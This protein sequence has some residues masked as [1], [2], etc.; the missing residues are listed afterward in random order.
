MLIK[1]FGCEKRLYSNVVR[2]DVPVGV[3]ARMNVL[4]AV[5]CA[6]LRA[7]SVTVIVTIIIIHCSDPLI[8]NSWSRKHRL[9]SQAPTKEDE[10]TNSKHLRFR[11]FVHF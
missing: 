8:I 3:G 10:C 2:R 5:L 7:V 9:K 4:T 11:G 6:V 1:I